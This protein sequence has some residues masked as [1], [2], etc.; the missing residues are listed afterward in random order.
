MSGSGSVNLIVD[1]DANTSLESRT[2]TYIVSGDGMPDAEFT[3]TQAGV[4]PVLTV[5]LANRD[6]SAASGTTTFDVSSNTNWVISDMQD[7]VI[8]TIGKTEDNIL[9]LDLGVHPEC[10]YLICVEHQNNNSFYKLIL[11]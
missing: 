9:N 1:F 6:V 8:Y 3:I 2:A 11:Q 7:V 10:V 5:T 4:D